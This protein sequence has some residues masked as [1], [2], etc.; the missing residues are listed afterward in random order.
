MVR[1]LSD[2]RP[3]SNISEEGSYVGVPGA[4]AGPHEKK[5][6]LI[7]QFTVKHWLD[8]PPDPT[9]YILCVGIWVAGFSEV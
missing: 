5:F 1:V 6:E 4:R 7:V 2:V 8:T 3:V 9:P